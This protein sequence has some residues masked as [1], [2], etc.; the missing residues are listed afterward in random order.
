MTM[1]M[2]VLYHGC[3]KKE[4]KGEC[5]DNIYYYVKIK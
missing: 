3:L 4:G 2:H 5:T 1:G